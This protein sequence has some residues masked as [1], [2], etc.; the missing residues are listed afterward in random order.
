MKYEFLKAS[1]P[2]SLARILQPATIRTAGMP[3]ELPL[4]G[5]QVDLL[6]DPSQWPFYSREYSDFHASLREQTKEAL[7]AL[8]PLEAIEGPAKAV[9]TDK[10]VHSDIP[11]AGD[12]PHID[13]DQ[14]GQFRLTLTAA[15]PNSTLFLPGVP[16]QD[17]HDPHF[18]YSENVHGPIIT[19][20]PGQ[21]IL[22]N[23]D[24]HVHAAPFEQLSI[25]Q[26]Q[27]K[28]AA[29]GGEDKW[30][31]DDGS[32]RRILSRIV[33]KICPEWA[34]EKIRELAI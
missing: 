12:Y 10:I 20:A 11:L 16:A 14:E 26:W 25:G 32:Y 19:P 34:H 5:K 6:S 33:F 31:F 7:L 29:Y 9:I 17:V 23:D 8:V 28:M 30:L 2:L 27:Q 3:C 24:L 18:Q 13:T 22:W 15:F 1:N 21:A 4:L